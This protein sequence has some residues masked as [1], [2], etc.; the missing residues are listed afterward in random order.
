MDPAL[1]SPRALK[2]ARGFARRAKPTFNRPINSHVHHRA[3]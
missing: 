3:A 1:E 2:G